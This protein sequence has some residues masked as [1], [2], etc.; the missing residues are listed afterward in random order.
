MGHVI[1]AVR[2]DDP[3]HWGIEYQEQTP[4]GDGL[5]YGLSLPREAV[6]NRMGAYGITDPAEALQSCI[7]Q[8]HWMLVRPA[9]RDD[10]AVVQGWV[11]ST[12]PDAEPVRV[13]NSPIG[14]DAAGAYAARMSACRELMQLSDPDGLLPDYTPTPE[15]VRYHRE[16]TD[17][18]RWLTVY[19]ALP[20]PPL[21]TRPRIPLEAPRA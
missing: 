11:T 12:T 8:A 15:R 1:T 17:T 3:Q 4:A 10:P 20:Q 19:G 14:A 21:D 18:T 2:E 5:V 6:A 9:P 16:L 13:Y 7:H